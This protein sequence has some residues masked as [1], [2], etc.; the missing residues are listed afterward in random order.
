MLLRLVVPVL[1]ATFAAEAIAQQSE[2]AAGRQSYR[3]GEFRTAVRHLQQAL[4]ADPND[5]ACNYWLGRSY[6]SLA[7]IST[8]FG[9]RYRSLARKYLTKAA[10]VAPDR[11]EYRHELFEFLLDANQER[12]ALSILLTLAESDPDYAYMLSRFEQVR[13][14]NSSVYARLGRLLH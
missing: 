12:Q 2:L 6:E 1:L 5:G 8:P 14:V 9:V 11:L 13:N 10:E 3:A 4:K 7:D